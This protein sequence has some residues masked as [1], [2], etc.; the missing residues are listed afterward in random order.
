MCCGWY[1][2]VCDC[3]VFV[4]HAASSMCLCFNV[5]YFS[6]LVLLPNSVCCVL[7][8]GVVARSVCWLLC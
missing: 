8:C 2:H 5:L 4:L 7:G 3:G 1:V 6:V